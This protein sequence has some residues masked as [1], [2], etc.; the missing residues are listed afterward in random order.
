MSVTLLN[1][2]RQP[3]IL[4]LD[5]DGYCEPAG[6]CSCEEIAGRTVPGSLTIRA[7][8][9][10]G[11]AHPSIKQLRAVRALVNAGHLS[12]ADS[13]VRAEE[14]EN[15]PAPTKRPRGRRGNQ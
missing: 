13:P 8:G 15:D 12:C 6:E 9:A 14:P 4:V 2:T 10:E 3:I 1:R 5:H 7:L 11:G